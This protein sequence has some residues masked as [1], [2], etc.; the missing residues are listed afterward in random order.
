MLCNFLSKFFKSISWDSPFNIRNVEI[1]KKQENV[2]DSGDSKKYIVQFGMYHVM[3]QKST[4]YIS[5][6]VFERNNTLFLLQSS[7]KVPSYIY[8]KEKF[9]VFVYVTTQ[10]EYC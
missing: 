8:C 10:E 5:L 1:K 2:Y 4:K 3:F 6:K 9:E 7:Q